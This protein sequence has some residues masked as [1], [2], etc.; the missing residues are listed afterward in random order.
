MGEKRLQLPFR[1]RH[2]GVMSVQTYLCKNWLQ[3]RGE[4]A[5]QPDYTNTY[6]RAPDKLKR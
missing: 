4:A 2:I 1:F 3:V 6:S 5:S